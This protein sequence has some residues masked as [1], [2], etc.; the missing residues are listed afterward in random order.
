MTAENWLNPEAV[1]SAVSQV[2]G[3]PR[4]DILG[5]K[6]AQNI[7]MARKV[8]VHLLYERSNMAY[9][10]IAHVMSQRDHTSIIYLNRQA[11]NLPLE[12]VKLYESK[13]EQFHKQLINDMQM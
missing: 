5:R 7:S 11:L 1:M 12:L 3:V 9:T 13:A 8:M 6:R 2:S 10:G 4:E